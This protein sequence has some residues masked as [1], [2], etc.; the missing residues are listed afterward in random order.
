LL[1][2]SLL[3]QP[4]LNRSV[5]AEPVATEPAVAESVVAEPVATEPALAEPVA[6]SGL[7]GADEVAAAS[8]EVIVLADLE[9]AAAAERPP[10]EPSIIELADTPPASPVHGDGTVLVQPAPVVVS[11]DELEGE[12]PSSAPLTPLSASP[13]EAVAEVAASAAPVAPSASPAPPVAQSPVAPAPAMPAPAA[14][15][16]EAS[17]FSRLSDLDQPVTLADDTGTYVDEGIGSPVPG[18]NPYASLAPDG[19]VPPPPPATNP[20]AELSPTFDDEFT[21]APDVEPGDWQAMMDDGGKPEER[22]KKRRFR[23]S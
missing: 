6:E 2:R 5:V 9:A 3:S 12:L 10:A 11:L 16:D 20:Y 17:V 8:P 22:K 18:Q 21:P 7:P 4:L 1:T 19:Y 15:A 13:P 14:V 23:R